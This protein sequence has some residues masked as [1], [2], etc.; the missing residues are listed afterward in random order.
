MKSFTY[1]LCKML[2][3]NGKLEGLNDKLD[4][5]Y[6]VG[7]LSAEEYTELCGMIVKR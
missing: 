1:T 7:R 3:D 5:F 4:V 2:I 6:S